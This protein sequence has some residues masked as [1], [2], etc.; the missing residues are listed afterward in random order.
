MR[1]YVCIIGEEEVDV[2]DVDATVGVQETHHIRVVDAP[3]GQDAMQASGADVVFSV[4]YL[5]QHNV[6]LPNSYYEDGDGIYEYRTDR[7]KHMERMIGS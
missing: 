3:S 1:S 5:R 4:D 6:T 7:E 2:D